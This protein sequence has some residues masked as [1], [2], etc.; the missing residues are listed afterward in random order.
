[1]KKGLVLSALAV[2]LVAAFGGITTAGAATKA[3]PTVK[4][5]GKVKINNDGTGTVKAHYIC[6]PGDDWHLWVSAKQTE[7]GSIDEDL[8]SE[9]SGFGHVAATWLQSHPNTYSCDGKWHTQKFEINKLEVDPSG[10]AIG[11]GE[12]TRGYAW[13][14]LCLIKGGSETEPP[15]LFLVDQGWAKVR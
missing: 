12:L 14:Q 10:Q 11:Y 2:V 15:E 5:V 13:V 3:E 1:M 6:P 4:M 8:A 9:G 7:D